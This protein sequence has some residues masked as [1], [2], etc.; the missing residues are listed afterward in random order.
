M[1]VRQGSIERDPAAYPT[2]GASV[3]ADLEDFV[4]EHYDRLGY[5]HEVVRDG[6]WRPEDNIPEVRVATIDGTDMRLIHRGFPAKGLNPPYWSPDGNALAMTGIGILVIK[7]G[8]L[9]PLPAGPVVG[10]ISAG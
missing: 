6:I 2:V 8:T 3:D 5:G 9:R 10:W 7:S 4:V 1:T